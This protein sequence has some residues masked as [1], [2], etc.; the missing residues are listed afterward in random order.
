MIENGDVSDHKVSLAAGGVILDEHGQVLLIRENYGRHRYGLPGGRIDA[1]ET[2]EDAVVREVREETGLVV[3]TSG[4]V[5]TIHNRDWSEPMLILVYRCHVIGGELAIQDR[6]E[7]AELGWFKP[8]EFSTPSTLSGPPAVRA[9]VA[10]LR[11]VVLDD[12]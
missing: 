5:G 2:P 9:A 10:G 7:I 6:D 8:S 1:G 11:G 4:L 3:T 12:L